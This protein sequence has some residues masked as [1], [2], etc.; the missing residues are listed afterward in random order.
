MPEGLAA[1]DGSIWRLLSKVLARVS[2][3]AKSLAAG[4]TDCVAAAKRIRDSR[5][6]G[7]EFSRREF[8]ERK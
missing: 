7:G 3:C 5:I 4:A 1:S 8:L 2:Y 6:M